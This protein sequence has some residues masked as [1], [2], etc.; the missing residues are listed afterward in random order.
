MDN[1][2]TN[3]SANN[4]EELSFLEENGNSGLQFKDILMLIIRNLPWFI[5]CALVGAGITYYKVK[6]QERIYA[7][8]ATILLKSGSSGGSESLRSSALINEF[9]GGGVALSSISNEMIIIKSQTLMENVVRRLNLNTMYS[10]NTR[11]AKRNKTLYNDS[12]VEVVFPDANEQLSASL[13]VTPQDGDVVV[14]SAFQGNEELPKM[15]V[16]VGDT[17]NT[18]VGK[19]KVR[20]TWYYNEGFNG[21]SIHVQHHPVSTVAT[22]YR[23][24]VSV[25]PDDERKNS[26]LRLSLT[27][28]SPTRAADVLNT[29]IEV[30]NEDSMEDQRRILKYSSQYID[31][32]IAF[33]DSDLDSISQQLVSFQQRHNIIN[34][35][36][37]GESY[38][39]SSI[40]YSEELK[41]LGIQ[42]GLTEYLLD[43]V[44]SNTDHDLIPSNMGLTGKSAAIIDKYNELVLQLNRYKQ[45]GTMNNPN[46]QAKL[47]ELLTLESSV[48]ESL[49]SYL[50]ELNTRI[51]SASSGRKTANAQVQTVP[52]E[53]LRVKDIESK[54]QIKEGLLLNMLTKREELLMNEPRIEAAAKVIDQAW[55]N[56]SPVAPNPKK[57]VGRGVLIGLLIPVVVIMLRRLLDTRVHFRGD[58]EQL[59]KTPF[60]GEIPLKEDAKD[61]AIVVKE[62]GRDSISEAF[63]LLRSNLEYMKNQDAKG[64]QVVMFTS[65]IVASGKTFVS[66]NLATSF[67]LANKKVVLVDLDIR[68]GTINKVFGVKPRVG[69]SNF[70]S[71]A[72]DTVDELINSD[73]IVQNMD[74]VFSGPVPPNP[75][76][77]LMSNRL[78]ELVDY[79]RQHYDYV[80]LD[81][82]PLGIVADS[83]IVKR[84]ADTTLFVIR[85]N[86]TDKRLI[87]ELDRIYRADKFPNLSVVL[88]S[89]KYKKHRGYGYGAYGYGYGYGYG[90][91]GYGYGYGGYGYGYGSYGYGYGYGNEE[92]E[93]K[94]KKK[95]GLKHRRR[96]HHQNYEPSQDD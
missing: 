11:I 65:F 94:K 63:R 96:H 58:V 4:S 90:G 57:A 14:L 51:E 77:L 8:S 22:W 39:A 53:Q 62:N 48:E 88:N 89:V 85:A 54:K 29:L 59:T 33:L 1:S 83:E 37:F 40:E 5:L 72:V 28:T 17:V 71:G 80:F 66:T 64:G 31:E 78:E 30:Y 34:V 49:M 52:V 68:K 93:G 95:H 86:K 3:V 2:K 47:T 75:A 74:V 41:Q 26:I 92:E 35:H 6:G 23:G 91:Y 16:H 69:V 67:A 21:I 73:M 45:A 15:T 38:L 18:P 61:H 24:S 60:L 10:Y 19:V 44:A 12:P 25:G 76:E 43:F 13:V 84:V 46:A 7:S 82:V 9:S 20:Y 42:K 81:N 36:D 55:P 70:L 32:R 56:Y 50:N 79:L 87:T 27:D